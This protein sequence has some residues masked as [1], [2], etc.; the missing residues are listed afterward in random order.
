[1]NIKKL[2]SQYPLTS[3]LLVLI[4]IAC[5]IPVPET[6]L[7]EV[8]MIDKWT[9]LVMFGTL[10]AVALYEK[11]TNNKRP[12]TAHTEKKTDNSH[13]LLRPLTGSLLFAWLTGGLIE[14]AQAYLTFGIRSGE[15]M[16]FLADGIGSALGLPIGILLA[17]CHAKWRK[18]P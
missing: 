15:W 14:L 8:R 16:D 1:M 18:V 17:T 5:M 7:S 10:S 9:H 2:I 6:P 13:S 12:T 4:W 11:I 3:A